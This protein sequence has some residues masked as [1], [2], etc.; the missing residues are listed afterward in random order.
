MQGFVSDDGDSGSK[1][2]G[3]AF[4]TC[5]LY[6]LCVRRLKIRSRRAPL[7]IIR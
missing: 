4:E 2:F 1:E 6:W 3:D 5:L 7:L